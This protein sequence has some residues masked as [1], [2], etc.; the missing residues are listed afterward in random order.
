MHLPWSTTRQAL[1]KQVHRATPRSM[2]SANTWGKT[3]AR[4]CATGTAWACHELVSD[5]TGTLT[6]GIPKIV[7][8]QINS[9]PDEATLLHMAAALEARSEHAA[10]LAIIHRTGNTP[11]SAKDIH[12]YPGA[13]I[14]DAPVLAAIGMS[15]SSLLVVL[16]ALRLTRKTRNLSD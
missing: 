2:P 8:V 13:S 12:N 10:A 3:S 6:V 9:H 1:H 15:S 4:Q 5:K 7:N 14:N 16:N 11:F